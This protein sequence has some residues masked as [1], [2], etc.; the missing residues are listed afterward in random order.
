MS[1]NRSRKKT[2]IFLFLILLLLL[3]LLC[4]LAYVYQSVVQSPERQ[5]V[6][7]GVAGVEF[8]FAAYAIEGGGFNGRMDDPSGVAY[9]GDDRIYVTLPTMDMVAVFDGDG[10]NGR[11][12]VQEDMS[13]QERDS[14]EDYLVISPLGIDVDDDGN[15]YVACDKKAA[16]VVFSPEGEKL[17][18]IR[19]MHPRYVHVSGDRV[20]VLGEGTMVVYDKSGTELGRWGTFGRGPDQLSWSA[21]LTVA[22]DGTILIADTNNYRVVAFSPELEVLW[23]FGQAASTRAEQD[24]RTLASPMGITVGADNRIYV[25]DGLNS[26]VRVLSMDGDLLEETLGERGVKDDQFQLPVGLDHMSDDLFVVADRF[27]NRILG[28]RLNPA[29]DTAGLESQ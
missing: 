28:V 14:L 15:V 13:V 7:A 8:E 2:R 26:Y 21:G 17:R 3:L 10:R 20:Y 27:N 12:F 29:E 5:V 4:G 1:E 23:T 11:V 6:A 18:E 16:V 22:P 9:D 19:A 25:I 24:V